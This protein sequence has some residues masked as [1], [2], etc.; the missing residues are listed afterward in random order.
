MFRMAD[1]YYEEE[2]HEKAYILYHKYLTL[3]VEKVGRMS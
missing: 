2:N 1:T 3:F